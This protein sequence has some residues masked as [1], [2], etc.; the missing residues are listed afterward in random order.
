MP[1]FLTYIAMYRRE[2]ANEYHII[3]IIFATFLLNTVMHKL[4]VDNIDN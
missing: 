4:T 3:M 2:V 1:I